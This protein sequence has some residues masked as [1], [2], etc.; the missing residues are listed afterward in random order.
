MSNQDLAK[1]IVDYVRASIFHA[2]IPEVVQFYRWDEMQE[3]V[4]W[5]DN[6]VDFALS[7]LYISNNMNNKPLLDVHSVEEYQ[8]GLEQFP[9]DILKFVKFIV[10]DMKGT[11]NQDLFLFRDLASDCKKSRS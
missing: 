5:I 10:V 4:N 9:S 1:E 11:N 2:Q 3:G 7:L 6:E 8:N